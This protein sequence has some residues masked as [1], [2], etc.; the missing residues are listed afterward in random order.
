M[1]VELINKRLQNGDFQKILRETHFY[2]NIQGLIL[3]VLNTSLTNNQQWLHILNTQF[4][5]L[6][7]KNLLVTNKIKIVGLITNL[8]VISIKINT[9]TIVLV[10]IFS[11]IIVLLILHQI[12][13]KL[14]IKLNIDINLISI[15]YSN[16]GLRAF[17]LVQIDLCLMVKKEKTLELD[18]TTYIRKTLCMQL[19]IPSVEAK[20]Y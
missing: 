3:L 2:K 4:H 13:M 9:L 7:Y 20:S 19:L 15:F 18:N 17:L 1:L 14:T 5:S 10:T 16:L 12:I 11:V 6:K 8:I